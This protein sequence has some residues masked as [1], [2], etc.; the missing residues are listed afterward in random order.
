MTRF[1]NGAESQTSFCNESTRPFSFQIIQSVGRGRLAKSTSSSPSEVLVKSDESGSVRKRRKLRRRCV[2]TRGKR[3]L[4]C[5]ARAVL[6]VAGFHIERKI[7]KKRKARQRK[8]GSFNL[9]VKAQK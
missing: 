8:G 1:E 3:E 7:K 9:S 6:E 2:G 5:K 4:T